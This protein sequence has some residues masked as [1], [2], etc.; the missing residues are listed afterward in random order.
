MIQYQFGYMYV[1]YLLGILLEDKV[2][3]KENLITLMKLVK[4][5]LIFIDEIF[6]G[7]QKISIRYENNK[8]RNT[9]FFYPF[10]LAIIGMVFPCKKR[11]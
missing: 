10:I 7:T 6:I 3:F 2:M 8:G 4:Q 9:Y 1:R 11:H 5:E